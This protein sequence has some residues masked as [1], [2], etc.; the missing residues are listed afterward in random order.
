MSY[1]DRCR[2]EYER[3]NPVKK[4]GIE[5]VPLLF[6]L[7]FMAGYLAAVYLGGYLGGVN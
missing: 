5:L 2:K 6:G 3:A 1:R 7:L 4:R